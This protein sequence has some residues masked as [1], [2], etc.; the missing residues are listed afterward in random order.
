[1][2]ASRLCRSCTELTQGQ[3]DDRLDNYRAR[4]AVEVNLG[5]DGPEQ[6]GLHQDHPHDGQLAVC[7]LGIVLLPGRAC[8]QSWLEFNRIS[9][10]LR[11]KDLAAAQASDLGQRTICVL[12][13][14]TSDMLL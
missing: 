11:S 6:Q 9:P 7:I 14:D 13:Q 4:D 10:I 8:I 1:M 5:P 3:D 12:G 2:L